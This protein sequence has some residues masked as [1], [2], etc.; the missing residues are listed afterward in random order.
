M[1]GL[2]CKKSHAFKGYFG[3]FVPPEV[4]ILQ[5]YLGQFLFQTWLI[6][7]QTMSL[8]PSDSFQFVSELRPIDI[9][10]TELLQ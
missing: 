1:A 3:D 4:E 7:K 5:E 2:A 6:V 10:I 8:N 9:H